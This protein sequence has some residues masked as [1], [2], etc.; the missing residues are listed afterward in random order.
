MYDKNE[1]HYLQNLLCEC[2]LGCKGTGKLRWHG[3]SCSGKR[4]LR[5]RWH[6]GACHVFVDTHTRQLG[7]RCVHIHFEML[8]CVDESQFNRL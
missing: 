3:N 2:H 4:A 1:T 6:P 5:Y 7:L 8:L